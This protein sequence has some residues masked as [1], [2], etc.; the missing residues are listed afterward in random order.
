MSK[1]VFFE[2]L[3]HI[4]Y[5]KAWDY[6]QQLQQQLIATK[7]ANRGLSPD[8]AAYQA[9]QHYLLFCEHPPVYTLGRNGSKDHLLLD[10]NKLEQEGFEFYKINRGGDITYHGPG[11]ILAYPIFDM[12]DFF[13]DIH[14]YVRYLEE[15][16]IRTLAG[17]G[18]TAIREEGY[19]G[20]WLPATAVLPKRKI[21]AIGIHL[22]RWVTLHGFAF[23]INAQLDHFNNIVPCGIA[24]ADRTVTSL[25]QELGRTVALSEV[26][27]K[28]KYHFQDL[29]EIPALLPV[30]TQTVASTATGA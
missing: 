23:N 18:L 6:Q 29:F 30:P 16:V 20:V 3:G 15:I 5:K 26:K 25:Q 14:K 11:Q 9:L 12:D 13:T 22:S 27:T 21:C 19:T 10:D 8:D 2:D 4:S 1:T 17:Y 7:R 28:L 24:E